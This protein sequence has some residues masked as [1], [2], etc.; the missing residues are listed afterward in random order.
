LEEGGASDGAAFF[1]AQGDMLVNPGAPASRTIN[2]RI[3]T[4][5]ERNDSG[6]IFRKVALHLSNNP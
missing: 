1:A 3:A 5:Q 2:A 4:V 6:G